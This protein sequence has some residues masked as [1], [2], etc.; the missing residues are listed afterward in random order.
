MNEEESIIFIRKMMEEKH[1]TSFRRRWKRFESQGEVVKFCVS[2]SNFHGYNHHGHDYYW[3]TFTESHQAYLNAA[4]KEATFII[5]CLDIKQ[6]FVISIDKM[7][8]IAEHLNGGYL[9]KRDRVQVRIRQNNNRYCIYR[10]K[11]EWNID[12]YRIE[13]G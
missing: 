7:N 13:I 1:Q 12:G 6:A 5:C 9:M 3:S 2:N 8:D 11:R 4:S 10:G